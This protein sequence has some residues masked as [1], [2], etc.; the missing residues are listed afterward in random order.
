[1]AGTY[2]KRN[3]RLEQKRLEAQVRQ[4][5]YD[6][7]TPRQKLDRLNQRLGFG[8]GAEKER[9]RLEAMP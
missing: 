7:L 8:L 1:M 9:A 6:K 2:P 5:E 4:E 3:E